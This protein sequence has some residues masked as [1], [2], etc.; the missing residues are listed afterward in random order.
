MTYLERDAMFLLMDVAEELEGRSE[1]KLLPE[2]Q[3]VLSRLQ[4]KA[5]EERASDGKLRVKADN[6]PFVTEVL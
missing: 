5:N 1:T 6:L 4:R 3:R 2:V